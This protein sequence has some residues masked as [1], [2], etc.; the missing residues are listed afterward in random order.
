MLSWDSSPCRPDGSAAPAFSLRSTP[1]KGL[2]TTVPASPIPDPLGSRV[3][4]SRLL[5]SGALPQPP[6]PRRHL[7][8]RAPTGH[9]RTVTTPPADPHPVDQTPTD[10]EPG[11]RAADTSADTGHQATLGTR[12]REPRGR[13]RAGGNRRL[14]SEDDPGRTT[15]GSEH[16]TWNWHRGYPA[17]TTTR[18]LIPEIRGRP[19]VGAIPGFGNPPDR[20]RQTLHLRPHHPNRPRPGRRPGEGAKRLNRR[21]RPSERAATPRR[22][23]DEGARARGRGAACGTPH[24]VATAD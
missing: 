15:L 12:A 11:E 20:H 1:P 5:Q 13:S 16:D 18:E 3:A 23:S 7:R 4:C 2:V 6:G 17:W 10:R 22:R 21:H 14:R 9:L 19:V 24:P 8:E